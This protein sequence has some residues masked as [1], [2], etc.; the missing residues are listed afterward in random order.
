MRKYS[1]VV[2]A[3]VCLLVALLY[4]S[5]VSAQNSPGTNI[6]TS[7]VSTVLRVTPGKSISTTISIENNAP[8]PENISIQ[9][10]TFVPDGSKG[11]ARVVPPKP[12]S[13]YI[14]WVHFSQTSLT[15]Q[16]GVWQQIQMTIDT[17]PTAALDYYYA[18][19]VKPQVSATSPLHTTTTIKGYN[20]VLVLLNAAS[21]NAKP[22]V[23]ITNFS[24]DHGVYEYLPTTFLVTAKNTGNVFL[25]P[26]GD[27]YISKTKDFSNPINTIPI[28]TAQGNI[29]PGTSRQY[30]NQWTNGFPLFVQKTVDGQPV[31]DSNGVP[32]ER[33]T[34]DF[35]KANQFR[36]GRYY[37][38]MVLVYNNGTIDVP[39]TAIVSF[40]VIPWKILGI[41]AL[42]I[43]LSAVGLYVSGHKLA[44]RTF[45]LSKRV[46]KK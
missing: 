44:S 11:Q 10:Q 8:T 30:A 28:N 19:L 21:P 46:R 14:S 32:I 2:G 40:W 27:I 1:L 37:A 38:K 41:V 12:N 20:A 3:V 15:A 34:W 29:I 22:E 35:A 31:S 33:L 9:L 13:P 6:T 16:P 42:I 25:S 45:S 43:I 39:I 17:P 24:A 18:V 26:T 4:P 7:P 36:F 23:E 5:S